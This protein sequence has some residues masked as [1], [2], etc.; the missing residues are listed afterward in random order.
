MGAS[1]NFGLSSI[2]RY[3]RHEDFPA[4]YSGAP[5]LGTVIGALMPFVVAS[6]ANAFG[7]YKAA[8]VFVAILAVVCIVCNR[9]FDPRGIIAYDNKLREAAGLPLDDVLEQ[10]LVREG[11]AHDK[12]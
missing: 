10:R 6:I 8:F 4:V 2:V 9:L 1:S 5:P 11:H 3:W 7:G 12:G